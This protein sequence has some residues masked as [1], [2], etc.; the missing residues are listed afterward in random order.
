MTEN[1]WLLII[2]LCGFLL[3]RSI[4][5]ILILF[6]RVSKVYDKPD[7]MRK[8]H[9]KV[10]PTLGG[11]AMFVSFIV[12]FSASTMADQM[13]GFGPFVAASII[14]FGIGLKDDL[15]GLSPR[16][17]FLAQ[18]L[19]SIIMIVGA[20][21]PFEALGG[22][23]NI[24]E[25]PM[26][27]GY[28]L[29]IFT[30][31]VVI[32]AFNLIDGVDGLAGGIALIATLFFGSW[33]WLAGETAWMVFSFLLASA[34]LGFLWYNFHPA[35]IFMGDTGSITLGFFVGLQ[36]IQFVRLAVAGPQVVGWQSAAPV[37]AV[38]VLIVP[39]F[40][41]LRVFVMRVWKGKSPFAADRYHI[42]HMLIDMGLSHRQVAITLYLYTMGMV[43]IGVLASS[44]LPVT[45]N[46]LL[47]IA[48]S[49]AAVPLARYAHYRKERRRLVELGIL[50][51]GG[52]GLKAAEARKQTDEVEG[53][54]KG[55]ASVVDEAIGEGEAEEF[56]S[57]T[58]EPSAVNKTPGADSSKTGGV[59]F[60]HNPSL[61]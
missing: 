45:E 37:L 30:L 25:I 55:A 49:V 5:P 48:L 10:T 43:L 33:F 21:Y 3:T 15:I 12:A 57:P 4:I 47:I 1:I 27:V 13:V 38:A 34:I 2:Y 39:L 36:A 18:A 14:L 24:T 59:S 22:V 32:N 35:K 60:P 17:R 6:A 54:R 61:N 26:Y 19:A 29:A 16:S 23:F 53:G 56:S 51:S 11:V 7:G 42:H 41:T 44:V 20:T 28:P 40:D 46:L 52:G 8:I 9:R 50:M 58:D 31:M